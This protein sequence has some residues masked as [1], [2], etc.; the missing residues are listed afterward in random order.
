MSVWTSAPGAV[1]F[2]GEIIFGDGSAA[3]KWRAATPMSAA[4]QQVFRL[5]ATLV[6]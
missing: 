3:L 5:R 6:P 2:L 1:I 4:S